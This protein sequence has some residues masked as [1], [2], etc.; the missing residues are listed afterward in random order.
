MAQIPPIVAALFLHYTAFALRW[1]F[2]VTH[3]NYEKLIFE[4]VTFY[5]GKSLLHL[6]T[7]HHITA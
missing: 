6:K 1:L 5:R 2:K 3:F 7:E 4:G